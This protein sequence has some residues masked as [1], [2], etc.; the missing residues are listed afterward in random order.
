MALLVQELIYEAASRD[1]DA[2]ALRYAG[3]RIGYGALAM[4]V[5]AA[6]GGLRA[7][8]VRA[9]DR[10]ALWLP[11]REEAVVALFGANAAGG[12]FVVPDPALAAPQAAALL[13]DC[14]ARVLVTTSE[15]LATL[16]SEL[17]RCPDLAAAVVCGAPGPLPPGIEVVHWDEL[18]RAGS[19]RA[20]PGGVDDDMAAL[21]YLRHGARPSAIILT[22][23]NVVAAART[24]QRALRIGADDRLLAALPLCVDA[25]LHQ[26]TTAFT[27]GAS[28]VLL[29]PMLARDVVRAVED[30]SVTALAALP[31]LWTELAELAWPAGG[32]SLRVAVNAGGSL[33]AASV[34]AL[35]RKLPRARIV[36]LHGQPEAFRATCLAQEEFEGHGDSIGRP[37]PQA[38]VLVLRPDGSPCAAGEPGELV[39]RGPLVARGYWNDS[40]RTRDRFRTLPARPGASV[41]ETALWTGETVSADAH[42]YLYPARAGEEIICT[43]GRRVRA[44]EVEEA[45]YATGLVEEAAAVGIAHPARGQVIAVMARA[46]T[47]LAIDSGQLFEACRA[48]LPGHMLPAMLDLRR[49]PLPRDAGGRIDRAGVAAALAPLF[50]EVAP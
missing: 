12:A 29:N 30:E 18:L 3:A 37:L 5:E 31:P 16:G 19:G 33:P 7:L 10:V 8:G 25:G 28:A 23:R 6:G 34:A 45:L 35:R 2:P 40:A 46:S 47:G 22:H 41:R 24:L 20:A 1:A 27:A 11:K 49:S 26:L 21:L 13:R 50:G 9:H 15:R 36:L 14:G 17:A 42:G 48:Q 4:M 44:A 32:G 43:G 39:Q 38:G